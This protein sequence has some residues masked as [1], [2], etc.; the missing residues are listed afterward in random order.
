MFR[1]ICKDS[2]MMFNW[3]E[4]V[5]KTKIKYDMFRSICKDSLIMFNWPEQ[6]V[7]T[8]IK[9]NILLCFSQTI[10]YFCCLLVISLV[11]FNEVTTGFV[12]L[13][14]FTFNRRRP[15]LLNILKSQIFLIFLFSCILPSKAS[16]FLYTSL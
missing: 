1:S 10:N 12:I 8:I 4:H 14:R 7:K 9:Y 13:F 11:I 6:V 16:V 15:N 2:L 3:P 5:V